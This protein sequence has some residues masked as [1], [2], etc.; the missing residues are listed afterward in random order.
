LQELELAANGLKE[1]RW[2]DDGV[3]DVAGGGQRSFEL[4]LKRIKDR[5]EKRRKERKREEKK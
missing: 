5:G 1:G 3:H 4:Q 2:A